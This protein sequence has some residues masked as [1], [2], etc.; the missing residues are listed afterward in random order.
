MLKLQIYCV[1]FAII[2]M[3]S[4][5]PLLLAPVVAL[6]GPSVGVNGTLHVQ[7]HDALFS[8]DKKGALLWRFE[9]PCDRQ[10][11]GC[12]ALHLDGVNGTVYL[13]VWG[14]RWDA[15]YTSSLNALDEMEQHGGWTFRR[16][17]GGWR[18]WHSVFENLQR[19]RMPRKDTNCRSEL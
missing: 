5:A 6:Y 9:V 2:T 4:V 3:W 1:L 13:A 11:Y 16:K 17:H 12:L 7:T 14:E 10:R 18:R 8:L 19:P 15:N